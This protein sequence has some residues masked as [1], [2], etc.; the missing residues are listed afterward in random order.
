VGVGAV[1]AGDDALG[2]EV[3]VGGDLTD[4]LARGGRAVGDGVD[5]DRRLAPA[6]GGDLGCSF[7]ISPVA[8]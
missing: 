5:D 6:E 2:R 1:D 7:A 8:M 3:R 4:G